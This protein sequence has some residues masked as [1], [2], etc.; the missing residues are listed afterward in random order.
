MKCMYWEC[1]LFSAVCIYTVKLMAQYAQQSH[2]RCQLCL[3]ESKKKKKKKKM[4]YCK[5]QAAQITV[6]LSCKVLF[7]CPVSFSVPDVGVPAKR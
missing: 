2:I 3:A 5:P 1:L 6:Q 7:E 4:L